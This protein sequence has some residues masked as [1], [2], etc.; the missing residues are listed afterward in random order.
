MHQRQAH[1]MESNLEE[2][3]RVYDL[4]RKDAEKSVSRMNDW[5]SGSVGYHVTELTAETQAKGGVWRRIIM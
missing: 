5:M 3:Q 4:G 1:R 2:I